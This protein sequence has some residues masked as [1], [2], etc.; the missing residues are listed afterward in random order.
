MNILAL[1]VGMSSVKAAVLDT[2]TALPIAAIAEADL[3]LERPTAEAAEVPVQRLWQAVAA[4]GRAA[5][6]HSGVSG[7]AGLDVQGVGLACVMAG[8]VL[9]DKN[10]QPLRLIWTHRDRRARP[11]AR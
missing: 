8:L 10:D 3:V 2:A 5:M 6:L 1:D 9:L 4:A 7:K 11:A